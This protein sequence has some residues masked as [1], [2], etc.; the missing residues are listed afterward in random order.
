MKTKQTDLNEIVGDISDNEG[1][2]QEIFGF[3][4][5][6]QILGGEVK[7]GK[8]GKY[9]LITVLKDTVER[10]VRSSSKPI[11]DTIEELIQKNSFNGTDTI[12]C[13]VKKNTSSNDN[14]FFTLV[15]L[16]E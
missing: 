10:K 4:T 3:D 6:I 16:K 1:S 11:I 12:S 9:A 7:E 2:I 14:V 5:E 15:G 13:K 8:K